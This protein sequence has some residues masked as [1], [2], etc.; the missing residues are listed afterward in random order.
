[1]FWTGGK[2]IEITKKWGWVK[3]MANGFLGRF[4]FSFEQ[5]KKQSKRFRNYLVGKAQYLS[6]FSIFPTE[7]AEF[8]GRLVNKNSDL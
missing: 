5:T 1:M 4:V 7:N 2:L 6:K 8:W 3:L